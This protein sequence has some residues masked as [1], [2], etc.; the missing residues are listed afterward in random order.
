MTTHY[1]KRFRMEFDLT[2]GAIPESV[3]IRAGRVIQDG[4]R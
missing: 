3:L 1:Y 4:P 2:R